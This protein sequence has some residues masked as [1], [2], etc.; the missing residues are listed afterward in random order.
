MS[1]PNLRSEGQGTFKHSASLEKKFKPNL[2]DAEETQTKEAK[3]RKCRLGVFGGK[4]V[5]IAQS[6]CRVSTASSNVKA[7]ILQQTTREGIMRGVGRTVAQITAEINT[8]LT[9]N[10]VSQH[11]HHHVQL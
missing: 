1:K 2:S 8:S 7:M 10:P 6:F 3:R 4:G 11:L 5:V 9:H